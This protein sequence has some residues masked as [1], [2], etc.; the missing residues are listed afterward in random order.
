MDA[1]V[2]GVPD[3]RI[4]HLVTLPSAFFEILHERLGAGSS[5][6]FH[7][8]MIDS[9]FGSAQRYGPPLKVIH[10][11]I[12]PL[13]PIQP[14]SGTCPT[15]QRPAHKLRPEKRSHKSG[16]TRKSVTPAGQNQDPRSRVV[17]P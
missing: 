4:R 8:A 10:I 12:F 9:P 13:L 11:S 15:S 3:G 16:I 17:V 14:Y 5:G 7:D 2:E 6:V 1:A